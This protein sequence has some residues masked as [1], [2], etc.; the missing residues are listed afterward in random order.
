MIQSN[1]LKVP[2]LAGKKDTSSGENKSLFFKGNFCFSLD[3]MGFIE[4]PKMG[5]LVTAR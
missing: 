3:L 5:S 2:F 4:F 1:K